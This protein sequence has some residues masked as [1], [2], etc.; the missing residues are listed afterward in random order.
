MTL[1]ETL[2]VV[3]ILVILLGVSFIGVKGLVDKI[4][5]TKLD[6]IAQSMYVSAQNRIKELR[7][8]GEIGKLISMK[9]DE[10]KGIIVEI[11]DEKIVVLVLEIG[12]RK[13]IC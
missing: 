7:A 9:D 13:N 8:T 6:N 5:Q 12:H 1:V 11:Q 3:A 10:S 4:N 2:I